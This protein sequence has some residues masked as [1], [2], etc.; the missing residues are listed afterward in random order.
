[1]RTLAA[2]LLACGIIA[3][4]AAAAEAPRQAPGELLD[5]AAD[6]LLQALKII[7]M[8]VPQYA[9]PEINENGDI[10]IRRIRPE[11]E[12]RPAPEP[13]SGPDGTVQTRT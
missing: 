9:A 8:A 4:P 5:E 2:A 13:E 7:L 1:M 12:R 10:V 11:Q 6:K 3:A